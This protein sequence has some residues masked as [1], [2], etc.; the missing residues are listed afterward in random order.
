MSLIVEKTKDVQKRLTNHG[1]AFYTS[2]R[3]FLEEHYVL[4][5]VGKAGLNDLHMDGNTRLCAMS[6]AASMR[7]SFGSDGQRGSYTDIKYT[8]CLFIIC[9]NISATQTFLWSR[10]LDRLEGPDPPK[11]I[12]IDPRLSNTAKKATVYLAPKIGTNMANVIGV[13]ELRKKVKTYNPTYVEEVTGIP[14]SKIENAAE[15]I[16]KP[17]SMLSN[18]LQGVYQSKQATAPAC[19]INNLNLLRG[20]IGRPGTGIYQMNSQPTAQNN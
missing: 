4:A 9:H 7:E 8:D 1:V 19:Q 2:G 11:V 13:E 12:V 18:A 3:L 10:M 20:L 17:P 15:I 16:G 14:A 5:M 6:A